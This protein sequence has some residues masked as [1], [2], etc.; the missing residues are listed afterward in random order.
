MAAPSWKTFL[1]SSLKENVEKSGLSATYA[2]I[3]TVRSNKTPAVRTVVMRG[4]VGEHHSENV[5]WSSDLLVITT[6]KRSDK[7]KEIQKNPNTEIN[8]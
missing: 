2:S 8:W 7:I 4:F 5:G 6:D 3:A 1:Q